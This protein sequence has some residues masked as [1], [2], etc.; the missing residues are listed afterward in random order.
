MKVFTNCRF[1][2]MYWQLGLF[3]YCYKQYE[4]LGYVTNSLLV[5]TALQTIYLFKFYVWETGYFCS[6]DIQHDRAGFYICWGCLVWVPVAYTSAG[7]F[8]VKQALNLPWPLAI[9]FFVAGVLSIYINYDS[10]RQRQDFRASEGKMKIWGKDPEY[11]AAQYT[12]EDGKT[13]GS[14]LLRSGWWGISRHFHY[15]P[16]IMGAFF[17]SV[18]ALFSHFMPY[19]YVVFLTLLLTDRAFRDD[20]RCAKKYGK[21]WDEYRKHV[22]YYIIPGII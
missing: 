12:T 11:I 8:M 18:P 13:R 17:W 4:D 16:E 10:D 22:P 20:A 7:Y 19:F 6:M 21:Y 5:C 3:C 14:L 2:L 15:V 1:G 9:F